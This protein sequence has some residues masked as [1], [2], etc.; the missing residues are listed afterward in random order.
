MRFHLLWFF[1]ITSEGT[2]HNSDCLIESPF[3]VILLTSPIIMSGRAFKMT[4]HSFTATTPDQPPVP[5]LSTV[6]AHYS[7]I[8]HRPPW[9]FLPAAPFSSNSNQS[10]YSCKSLVFSFD[11]THFHYPTSVLSLNAFNKSVLFPLRFINFI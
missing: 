9:P 2:G 8:V 5:V 3:V 1:K 10:I 6:T 7:F 11:W 4:F